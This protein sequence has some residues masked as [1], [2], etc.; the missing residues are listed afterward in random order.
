MITTVVQYIYSILLKRNLHYY[1]LKPR[2]RITGFYNNTAWSQ[3]YFPQ[4]GL[5]AN[6]KSHTLIPN[7]CKRN[8]ALFAQHN[9]SP[10]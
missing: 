10:S 3:V 8:N 6:V 9:M 1:I 5:H 4:I 7:H 2:V